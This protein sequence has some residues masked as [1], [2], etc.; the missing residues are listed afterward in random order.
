MALVEDD[1]YSSLVDD[2]VFREEP[3]RA[4]KSW[5]DSGHVLHCASLHKHLAP[6]MR[7]GWISGGRWQARVE[8][9]KFTQTRSNEE[10]SQLAVADY[11]AGLR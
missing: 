7:L 5:D 9:L 8:M 3:L 4:I 6:G 1:T 2:A 10:L 11:M